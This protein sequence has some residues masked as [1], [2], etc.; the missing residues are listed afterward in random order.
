MKKKMNM[1]AFSR[2]FNLFLA[3][4]L[5]LGCACPIAASAASKYTKGYVENG[6]YRLLHP[7]SG[8]YVDVSN[9]SVKD[10]T[11]LHL[12]DKAEGNQKQI[13]HS[14]GYSLVSYGYSPAPPYS[15][16]IS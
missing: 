4:V 14:L 8:K 7:A 10:G 12:W 6:W 5:V 9:V 2:S 15:N 3:T 13:F 16:C 11:Y 1:K